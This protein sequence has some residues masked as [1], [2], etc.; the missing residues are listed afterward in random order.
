[1]SMEQAAAALPRDLTESLYLMPGTDTVANKLTLAAA[2]G[3]FA[4]K[5]VSLGRAAELAGRDTWTFIDVLRSYGV[6]WADYTDE[7]AEMDT[8]ALGHLPDSPAR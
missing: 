1:M 3:L 7:C 4:S 2:I 6:P 8:Q 5:T